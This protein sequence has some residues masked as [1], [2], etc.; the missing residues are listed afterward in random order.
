MDV[1]LLADL[2]LRSAEFP[3]VFIALVVLWLLILGGSVGSFLNV[4][5]YRLPQGLSLV[6]PGSRCPGCGTP[7]LARD[8][9]P[10]LGWLKLRGRCRACR[11]PISLRYPLV[12]LITALV[13]LSLALA[14]PLNAGWNLPIPPGPAVERMYPFWGILFFHFVLFCGL[15]AAALMTY[16]GEAVPARLW[17]IVWLVGFA[18]PC[19]WPRL[20]PIG[21]APLEASWG[22]WIAAP[23]EGLA[24][25]LMGIAV[26]AA[27]WPA[28]SLGAPGRSGHLSGVA[29]CAVI[30]TFLGWQAAAGIAFLGV[31]AWSTWQ[32]VR[33][34]GGY[35]INLPW[36]AC[37][38]FVLLA[39]LFAWR[40]IVTL[41]PEM[42][43]NA[44]WHLPPVAAL[45]TLTV[46]WAGRTL[47]DSA[48][49]KS[50]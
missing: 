4:V 8:N 22:I 34:L 2:V 14:E 6:H 10:A 43:A 5:V 23:I 25:T 1:F 3:A 40:Y 33:Y 26:G 9:I 41:V 39:W 50:S 24:G 15:F 45:A 44:P 37:L 13:F 21:I 12:E 29:A 38:T 46:A 32:L 7:I 18:A 17:Q 35:E 30:G 11:C 16:D 47:A 48:R 20:R 36:L 31:L 28:S 19:A 49:R 27:S 42:D